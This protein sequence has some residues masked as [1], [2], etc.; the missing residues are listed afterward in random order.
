[1]KTLIVIGLLALTQPCYAEIKIYQTT[2]NTGINKKEQIEVIEAYLKDLSGML[3]TIEA[4]VEADSQRIKTMEAN[5]S[6]IREQDIK[7]LQEQVTKVSTVAKDPANETAQQKANAEEMEKIKIDILTMKNN[8]IEPLRED[9]GMIRASLR[10]L[11]SAVKGSG[12]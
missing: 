9:I 8:D 7:K 10:N 6:A 4:R 1:M 2:D 11:Q 5:I 12:K 3:K